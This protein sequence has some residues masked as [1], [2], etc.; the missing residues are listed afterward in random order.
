MAFGRREN[1][2]GDG[3]PRPGGVG[4]RQ[5]HLCPPSVALSNHTPQSSTASPDNASFQLMF[6]RILG[7]LLPPSVLT[8]CFTPP[9]FFQMCSCKT[10]NHMY[11]IHSNGQCFHITLG[12]LLRPPAL[13]LRLCTAVLFSHGVGSPPLG[14]SLSQGWA[15]HPPNST[16]THPG[17]VLTPRVVSVFN[18]TLLLHLLLNIS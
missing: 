13:L 11:L 7:D 10:I 9:F 16:P 2:S 17:A 5:V 3:I 6:S 14:R 4:G 12:F 8:Y 18:W 1:G 15:T